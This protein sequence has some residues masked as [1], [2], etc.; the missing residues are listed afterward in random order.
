MTGNEKRLKPIG[1]FDSGIGGLGILAEAIKLMPNES[2]VYYGDFANA[3]YGDKPIEEIRKLALNVIEKLD[4]IG[5]KSLVVACNTATSAAILNIRTKYDFPIIGTEPALKP[6]MMY[7]GKGKVLVMATDATLMLDKYKNLMEKFG[8][9]DKVIGLPC[10][11]L[12]TLIDE[13][14]SGSK[15]IN[16]YLNKIFKEINPKAI[17]SV[18]LGC[19]HYG[20][21]TQDIKE[22]FPNS[23]IYDTNKGVSKR[24]MQLLKENDLISPLK[25][26]DLTI[27]YSGSLKNFDLINRVLKNLEVSI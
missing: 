11:G 8:T 20:L 3:P 17:E 9:K 23:I 13:Y 22:F 6:A 15:E 1:I 27:K 25:K 16:S 19:T 5:I 2:F 14:D 7:S 18:V 24:L 10:I 21:I 26:G 4:K 12:S